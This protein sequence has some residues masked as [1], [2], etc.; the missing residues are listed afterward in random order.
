MKALFDPNS[1]I[2]R[3]GSTVTALMFLN[4]LVVLTSIPIV[5]F[6]ASMAAMHTMML[7]IYRDEEHKL[8]SDYFKAFR[9]N[10][11]Q[12]TAIWIIY[13]VYFAALLA[14]YMLIN[15]L[16]G[17]ST[18]ATL[19][20][21]FLLGLAYI[22]VSSMLWAFVLQSRYINPVGRTIRNSLLVL[23]S[24]V[25]PSLVMLI[26]AVVSGVLFFMTQTLAAAMMI[27]ITA[28]TFF[29]TMLYSRVFDKLEGIDRSHPAE[30][31][32]CEE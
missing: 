14:G 23:I 29:V 1:K 26:M 25:A 19:L 8:V 6:G 31:E 3:F 30:S 17:P 9:E 27:G 32:S 7:K 22:G 20:R 10:L 4:L 24:N 2:Y 21:F 15:Q 28:P 11:K 5:T 13:I 16:G 18:V 12:A